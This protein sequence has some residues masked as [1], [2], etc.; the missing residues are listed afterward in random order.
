MRSGQEVK[1]SP[2][3]MGRDAAWRGALRCLLG[4]AASDL[5]SLA[6]RKR[7]ARGRQHAP[8]GLG[9]LFFNAKDPLHPDA[10]DDRGDGDN[11]Y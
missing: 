5:R 3:P 2:Y 11:E 6:R 7:R 4:E 10:Q 1:G 8:L 9:D